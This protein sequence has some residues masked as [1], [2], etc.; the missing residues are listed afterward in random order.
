MAGPLMSLTN[1][2]WLRI[3]KVGCNWNRQV[4]EPVGGAGFRIASVER[5][6]FYSTAAP[7]TFPYLLIKAEK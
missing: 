3:N 5:I 4:E 1:R 7:A 2:F 6:K